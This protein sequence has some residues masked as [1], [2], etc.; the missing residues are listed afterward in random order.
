MPISI[1]RSG[2]ISAF[3][4]I[5][6]INGFTGMVENAEGDDIAQYTRDVLVGA[7]EAVENNGGEVV[8]LMGDAFYALLSDADEVFKCC[9][10]IA[11]DLDRQC[12]YISECQSET[13]ELFSFSPGGPGLK[14]GIEYGLL[15][16]SPIHSNYLKAQNLFIGNAVNYASRITAAGKGNRCLIGPKAAKQGLNQYSHRGPFTVKGK[17]GEKRYTYF[18]L[19][20]D[21][22]WWTGGEARTSWE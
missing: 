20:L 8:G 16:I 11:K 4:M 15:D 5:V 21:D 3:A 17:A 13:P 6:D 19:D 7:I 14:I 18:E 22:I 2:A 1:P 10:G 12:E 9:V